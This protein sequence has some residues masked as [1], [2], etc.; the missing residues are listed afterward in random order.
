MRLIPSFLFFAAALSGA[1]HYELPKRGAI[2]IEIAPKSAVYN[3]TEEILD[4][5]V[6][7]SSMIVRAK[8]RSGDGVVEVTDIESED[9]RYITFHI[10]HETNRFM[11]SLKDVKKGTRITAEE[12]NAS[13]KIDGNN[14]YYNGELSGSFTIS[15]TTNS[16]RKFHK[17]VFVSSKGLAVIDREIVVKKGTS[18]RVIFYATYKTIPEIIVEPLLGTAEI[19]QNSILFTADGGEDGLDKLVLV[20]DREPIVMPIRIIKDSTELIVGDQKRD[21]FMGKIGGRYYKADNFHED[22]VAL[23]IFDDEKRHLALS[24]PSGTKIAI[25]GDGRITLNARNIYLT[26]DERLTARAVAEGL[27]FT[28]EAVRKI[29]IDGDFNLMIE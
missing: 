18:R 3:M 15:Y 7:Q 6:R 14:I 28:K 26:L 27:Q 29:D 4:V 5:S 23:E 8:N 25:R 20:L 9:I 11:V 22:G 10:P 16:G 24:A 2:E 1:D 19:D 13:V 21:S 17:N 12:S